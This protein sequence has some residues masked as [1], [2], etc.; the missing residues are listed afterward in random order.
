MSVRRTAAFL[1]VGLAGVAAIATGTAAVA[2][3]PDHTVAIRNLSNGFKAGGDPGSL[4]IVVAKRSRGCV[5]VRRA[6]TVQLDGLGGDQL[7][8]ERVAG[9]EARPMPLSP[10]GSG[11]WVAAERN[12]D[13]RPVCAG[14][15]TSVRFRVTFLAGAPA[16][17][18]TFA[19]QAFTGGGQSLGGDTASRKVTGGR[20]TAPTPT[21]P[22][23]TPPPTPTPTVSPS[24]EPTTPPATEPAPGPRQ[25]SPALSVPLSGADSG[26]GFG[27]GGLVM[28]LGL[29]M[30][31]IGGA[32]LVV[33][34][35]RARGGP[36]EPGEAG[37]DPDPTLIL[38]T[39]RG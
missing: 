13:P 21:R 30:V 33:L 17:A 27:F 34:L 20:N 28:V 18:A 22:A 36:G 15:S 25:E 12:P 3:A 23:E 37:G 35:R 6:L 8:I 1:I 4:S 14:D 7:R 9:G 26:G 2:A 19:A 11:A 16:G 32:L 24:A 38:P 5:L 39:V 10:A 29:A 31:A